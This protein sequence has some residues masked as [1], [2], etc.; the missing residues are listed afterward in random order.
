MLLLLLLISSPK[1]SSSFIHWHLPGLGTVGCPV[2]GIQE[3]NASGAPVLSQEVATSLSSLKPAP[4]C[5]WYSSVMAILCQ[6][7]RQDLFCMSYL[8]SSSP[9]TFENEPHEA[10]TE[11]GDRPKGTRKWVTEAELELRTLTHRPAET[12]WPLLTSLRRHCWPGRA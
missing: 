1:S 5:C 11:K 2:W 8:I 4:S 10:E 3:K 9:H 6:A 7:L 12:D